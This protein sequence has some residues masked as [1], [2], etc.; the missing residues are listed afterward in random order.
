MK[1][2]TLTLIVLLSFFFSAISQV[3]ID[4]VIELNGADGNRKVT[5]LEPP[6][7]GTDAANKDY[8]DSRS[9]TH[10]PGEIAGGGIVYFVFKS[11]GEDHGYIASLADVDG[12]SGYIWSNVDN[13]EIGITAQ[14]QTDGQAN[15]AAIISQ[16]GHTDSAAKLCDEYEND[17]YDDWYLPA[18]RE[19]SLL[20]HQDVMVDE[21][22]DND[23]NPS[24]LGLTQEY[25][26]FNQGYYW[27]STEVSDNVDGAYSFYPIYGVQNH[28]GKLDS[29]RVRCIRK[30]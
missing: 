1:K 29:Y 5:Q 24:T 23:G 14:S 25:Y 13:D 9:G 17:G 12:G 26:T 27:S 8:V 15:T 20:F 4:Q 16:S 30:F 11:N 7:D 18:A 28:D 19:L 22:L 21:V 10:F 2:I 3:Q 6:A